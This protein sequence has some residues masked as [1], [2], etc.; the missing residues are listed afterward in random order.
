MELL[1]LYELWAGERLF[2]EKAHPRYLRP[3]RPISVSAVP[4]GPGIDIWR[5]CRFIGALMRSLCLLPAGL[6]RFVPCSIGANHCRLRHIGW[7]KCGY[8]LTSRPRESASE[9]FFDELLSLFRYPSRSGRALLNGTLPLRY[10]AVRFAHNTPTWRL[11][12]SGQV[13]RLVAAYP[14]SAGD[15]SGE[16]FA[17]GV[18]LVSRSSPVRIRFRLNRKTPAHL[19]GF[20]AH[21]RPRVW[22]RLRRV[23]FSDPSMPDHTR[24]RCDHAVWDSVHGH[25]RV[26][27]GDFPGI[28]QAHVY[29]FARLFN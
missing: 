29:R 1:I 2:L 11:P 12:V 21:S 16:G 28:M 5:S 27:V 19:A 24:R 15:C 20:S 26:G 3:R 10:C 18:P 6:R 9:L 13:S 23:G 22:K 4:S 14:D 17:F 8:G 7:E 25:D